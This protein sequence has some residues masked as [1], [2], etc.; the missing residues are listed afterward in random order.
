MTEQAPVAQIDN[1]PASQPAAE[2]AA[3]AAW[4]SGIQDESL[5]GYLEMKGFKGPDALAD[6]YRNLEKLRGV[7]ENELLRLPK[8]GDAEAWGQFY[9]RLGRPKSPDDYGLPV[10]EGDD[11][12]FAKTAAQWMHEAGLTPAQAKLL[13]EKNNEWLA[14]QVQSF[15]EQKAVESDRQLSE[16]KTEWGQ[17]FDQNVEIARRAANQFGIKEDQMEALEDALGTKGMMQL[18]NNIGQSLGEHKAEGFGSGQSGFKL[19]PEA[20]RER[21]KQLGADPE[22]S[23]KYLSGGANEAAEMQRLQQMANPQ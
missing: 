14:Q 23:K 16:L 3:P 17:A 2:P 15:N 8:E 22:W 18:F 19:S 4:Y 9:D 6:S 13:G 7:P 21:I 1:A 20:A 5:R 10:P 12:A 11:G